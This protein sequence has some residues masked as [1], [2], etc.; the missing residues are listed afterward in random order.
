MIS[1]QELLSTA[2]HSFESVNTGSWPSDVFTG[3]CLES[4]AAS[5]LVIARNSVNQDVTNGGDTRIDLDGTK[6]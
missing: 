2:E 3:K 4:I 1:D 5:L 6:L